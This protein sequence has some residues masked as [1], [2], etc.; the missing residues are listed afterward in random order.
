[1]GDYVNKV[2]TMILVFIMLVLAPLTFVYVKSEAKADKL[3]M[4]EVTQF[5]DKV[6]DKASIT[7]RD[8][9]DLYMGVNASGGAY[10]V[11]IK[12]YIRLATTDEDGK[13]RTIWLSA[14]SEGDMNLGDR[15]KVTVKSVGVSPAKRLLW[16]L[17]RIDSGDST[18]SLA[19]TVR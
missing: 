17:L 10:D 11:S 12:R 4:N 2:I 9:D 7:E 5:L 13:A 14:D 19:S 18:F 8:K 1:M 3:A 16:S 15:V 6:T